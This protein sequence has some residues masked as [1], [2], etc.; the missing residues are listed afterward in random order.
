MSGSVSPHRLF[1]R[2]AWLDLAERP[3][4]VGAE[5]FGDR[6]DVDAEQVHDGRVLDPGGG[7]GR[8]ADGFHQSDAG[9]LG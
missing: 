8:L 3:L 4:R 1:R 9:G 6:V 7:A 5:P 2:H